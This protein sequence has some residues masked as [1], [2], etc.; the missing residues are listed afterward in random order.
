[1]MQSVGSLT[2]LVLD[3][4]VY[5]CVCVCV[6]VCMHSVMSDSLQPHKL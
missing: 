4:C 2:Y 3:M 6:C 5:V 1:M